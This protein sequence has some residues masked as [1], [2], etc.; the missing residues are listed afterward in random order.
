M[1]EQRT[2][3]DAAELA[4]ALS[5]FDLGVLESITPLAKGSSRSPKVGIVAQRGK[6]LLKRRDA[7]NCDPERI[8]FSHELQTHLKAGGFPAPDVIATR[9]GGRSFLRLQDRVYE[10]F[11]FIAGQRFR[12]TVEECASAGATL[13]AFHQMTADLRTRS[14]IP[15]GDYHDNATVRRAL[16]H[17]GAEGNGRSGV[18]SAARRLHASYDRACAEARE[19][20]LP[21]FPPAVIHA[22][23]HPGNMLFRGAQIAA[24]ID[25]DSVRVSRRIIDVA[26]GALQFSMLAGGTLE[27]WPE[28]LDVPR[29]HAFLR[30][31]EETSRFAPGERTCLAPLMREALIA[32]VVAPIART[33]NFG[34]HEA[35]NFLPVVEKKLTWLTQNA[36][37]LTATP[38]TV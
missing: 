8:R 35:D 26:N 20:G 31:Y 3:F 19:C 27:E 25:Y 11:E 2:S 23:W 7:V 21:T 1:D 33:G 22:D 38:A 34:G 28:H 9:S 10:L 24:V 17:L 6:F 5:H 30:G 32:E 16:E 36:A 13:S 18:A 29:F 4:V 15:R 14:A 12:G 37:E